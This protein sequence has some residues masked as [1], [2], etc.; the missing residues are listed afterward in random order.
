MFIRKKKNQALLAAH[1]K[2]ALLVIT[3]LPDSELAVVAGDRVD[4]RNLS[5]KLRDPS[6]MAY[7]QLG[8]CQ[9]GCRTPTR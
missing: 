6:F 9:L 7:C 8:H 1:N 3:C 4:A 5:P 2:N